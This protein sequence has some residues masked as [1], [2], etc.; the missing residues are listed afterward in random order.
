MQKN[1]RRQARLAFRERAPR[2]GIYAFK[3]ECGDVW[4]G[5]AANLD[6]IVNRVLFTLRHGSSP[7][8]TLQAA[9]NR[10]GGSGITHVELEQLDAEKL[11]L[12]LE[13]VLKERHRF[14]VEKLSASRI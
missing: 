6:T 8:R 14:W 12:G 11:G 7:H 9:W 4:V 13:R 2:P 5:R 1:E 3:A 10:D